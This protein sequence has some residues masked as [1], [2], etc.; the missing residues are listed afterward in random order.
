MSLIGSDVD[1]AAL[2]GCSHMEFFV[3]PAP[4][5]GG[6]CQSRTRAVARTPTTCLGYFERVSRLMAEACLMEGKI[7]LSARRQVMNKFRDAYGKASKPD[8]GRIPDEVQAATGVTRS[9]ARREERPSHGLLEEQPRRA[10]ARDRLAV[11]HDRGT[12]TTEP[13]LAPGSLRMNFFTPTKKPIGCDQTSAGRRR[14]V[15]DQPKTPWQHVKC[16]DLLVD[17][18]SIETRIVGINPAVLTRE[19]TAIQQQLTNLAAEKTQALTQ[20]RRL[21]MA[22]LEKSIKRLR[23]ST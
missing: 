23:P 19:I 16:S 4:C 14:R 8:A 20:T 11:R 1:T 17:V 5:C 6:S 2:P 18:D 12:R 13:T 15:Y 21:D 10:K 9:T 22:P 7:D 3:S